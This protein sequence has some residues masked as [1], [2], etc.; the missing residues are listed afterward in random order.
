[1]VKPN[2]N[3]LEKGYQTEWHMKAQPECIDL[4]IIPQIVIAQKNKQKN[5]IGDNPVS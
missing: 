3:T 2:K 5:N 1:M 4:P